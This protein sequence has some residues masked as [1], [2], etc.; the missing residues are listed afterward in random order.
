L[1]DVVSFAINQFHWRF[2]GAASLFDRFYA[3]G[4]IQGRPD[5]RD[6][7]SHPE[8]LQDQCYSD[9]DEEEEERKE[10]KG[11]SYRSTDEVIRINPPDL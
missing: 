4:T 2:H 10:M 9:E 8:G 11:V 7:S 6:E 1:K 5:S 3:T